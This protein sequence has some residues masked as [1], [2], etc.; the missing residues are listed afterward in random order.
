MK[1]LEDLIFWIT[2]RESIRAK[3]DA[4]LHRPWTQDPILAR[5]KFCN[6]RREHDRVT[7]WIHNHWLAPNDSDA[8]LP[9]NMTV[10]RMVNWPDTLAELGYQHIKWN[11]THFIETLARRKARGAKVWTGAY[12]I[13]GGF[14]AGGESKEV[15]IA[16]VLDQAWDQH[17]EDPVNVNDTLESAHQKLMCPGIGSFLGA[18][19]VADLKFSFGHLA[20]A[21]DWWTWCAP[22]PGSTLGLNYLQDRENVV[23]DAD[24]FMTEVNGIRQIILAETGEKLCAQNTQNCLCEF[25][26]YVRAKYF[27][28]RLKTIYQ[29]SNLPI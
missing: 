24:Q 28:Q 5:Y 1:Y 12:M 17:V 15:I 7:K 19:I 9:F 25:S 18:Q 8:D 4:N 6:V 13:T 22:G 2:E 16:R 26:K 11:R 14:S 23:I 20:N 29:P 10:A 27:G 21:T 3:K